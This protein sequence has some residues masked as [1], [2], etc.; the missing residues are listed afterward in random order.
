MRGDIIV[1]VDDRQ[2]DDA[3]QLQ[4]ALEGADY[5][6]GITFGVIRGRQRGSI[7]VHD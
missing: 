6:N 1:T 3:N 4:A 7:E 5:A 2:I